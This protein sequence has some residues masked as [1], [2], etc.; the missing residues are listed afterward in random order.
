MTGRDRDVHTVRSGHRIYDRSGG[1]V[2]PDVA[3]L[4]HWFFQIGGGIAG[5]F[6]I[7][8]VPMLNQDVATTLCLSGAISVRSAIPQPASDRTSG[9]VPNERSRGEAEY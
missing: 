6:P 5:E 2:S 1:V 7:C 9:A 4:V 3:G 8:V